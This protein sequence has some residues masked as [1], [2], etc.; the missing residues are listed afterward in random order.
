MM[1]YPENAEMDR[2]IER[3]NATNDPMRPNMSIREIE[4]LIQLFWRWAQETDTGGRAENPE[5]HFRALLK[6]ALLDGLRDTRRYLEAQQHEAPSSAVTKEPRVPWT[7]I[8]QYVKS[9]WQMLVSWCNSW[10][11]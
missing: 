1:A 7:W 5:E 9:G 8:I 6:L 2:L 4:R 3:Y 11:N 10:R